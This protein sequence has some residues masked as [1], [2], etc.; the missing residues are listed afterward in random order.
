MWS[1]TE[2]RERERRRVGGRERERGEERRMGGRLVSV[3]GQGKRER[4]TG[5]QF[6][7]VGSYLL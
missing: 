2:E 7:T 6:M 5:F 3:D 4:G 1:D